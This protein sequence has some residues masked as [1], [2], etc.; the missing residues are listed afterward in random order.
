MLVTG[1]KWGA[2]ATL[3]VFGGLPLVHFDLNREEEVID[4]IKRAGEAFAETV[5]TKFKVPDPVIPVTDQRCK[6]CAWRLT[7]RG[8]EID[9]HEV[10]ALRAM[11]S[12]RKKLVQ[13]ENAALANTLAEIDLLTA[14]R[15]SIEKSLEVAQEKALE[16]LGD[17]E[18]GYVHGYGKV[19]KLPSQINRI[20]TVRLKFEKPEVYSKYITHQVGKPYLRCY[21][22][23]V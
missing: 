16:Q 5:W 18:A 14:E 22:N 2:L 9:R 8:Q 1:H 20:D 7:C 15:K 23:E 21:P 4:I 12:G 10:A 17:T 3:G 11:Q 6:V 19:Y 13:I